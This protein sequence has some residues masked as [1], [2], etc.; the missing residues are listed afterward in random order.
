MSL[1][2]DAEDGTGKG[3]PKEGADLIPAVDLGPGIPTGPTPGIPVDGVGASQVGSLEGE[4]EEDGGN[5]AAP[6]ASARILFHHDGERAEAA[7]SAEP[8]GSSQP[9]A[10]GEEEDDCWEVGVEV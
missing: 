1:A 4:W 6:I 9:N 2:W 10:A 8:E 3:D 5:D 7:G